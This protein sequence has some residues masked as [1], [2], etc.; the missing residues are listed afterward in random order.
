MC[1]G[2]QGCVHR[3]GEQQLPAAGVTVDPDH[4]VGGTQT[5]M[6]MAGAGM[7][8]YDEVGCTEV[9]HLGLNV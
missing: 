8:E 4:E 3:H 6:P 5:A 1:L 2:D 9:L 7:G